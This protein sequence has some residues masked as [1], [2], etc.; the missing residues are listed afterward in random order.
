MGPS[1]MEKIIWRYDEQLIHNFDNFGI[2]DQFL[3]KYIVPPF[4][5]YELNNLNSPHSLDT[6]S[7]KQYKNY[8]FTRISVMQKF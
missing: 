1:D 7:K 2:M 8:Q 6:T 5:Q 4:T 3:E